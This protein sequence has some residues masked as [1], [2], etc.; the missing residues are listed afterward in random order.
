M[1]DIVKK[2]KFCEILSMIAAGQMALNDAMEKTTDLMCEECNL[3]KEA[4]QLI[5]NEIRA[6]RKI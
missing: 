3:N 2:N 6:E 4:V 1:I 5:I